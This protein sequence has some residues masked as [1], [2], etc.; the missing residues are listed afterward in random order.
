MLV[1]SNI[2][3]QDHIRGVWHIANTTYQNAVDTLCGLDK[4]S[5]FLFIS[6]SPHLVY[7]EADICELC[8]VKYKIVLLQQEMQ[9]DENEVN[10]V[11]KDFGME[12]IN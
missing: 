7:P 2:W 10:D 6:I 3:A 4:I 12:R 11:M 5:S 8:L 9:M 1:K